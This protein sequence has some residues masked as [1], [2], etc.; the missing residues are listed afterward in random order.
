MLETYLTGAASVMAVPVFGG[1][2]TLLIWWLDS[3]THSWAKDVGPWVGVG[4]ILSV[5]WPLVVAVA[6]LAAALVIPCGLIY[7]V[8]LAIKRFWFER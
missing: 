3:D 2:A 4:V 5:T 6:G 1:L 7:C 8:G